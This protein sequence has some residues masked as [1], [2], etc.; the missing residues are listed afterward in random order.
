MKILVVSSYLPY[1]LFSGGSV[2]LFNLLKE[3]SKENEVTLVCEI[4]K[5]Q[6]E[7][8]IAELKKICKKVITVKRKKQWSSGNVFKSVFSSQ[9]FLV[10]GHTLSSMKKAIEKE[11]S[12]NNFDLIHVET[13]YVLQNVPKTT[14][15]IVLIEHNIEYL[16]Y[17]RFVNKCPSSIRRFLRRDVKKI[18]RQEEEAWNRS[19]LIATVSDEDKAVIERDDVFVVRNGVDLNRFN[20]SSSKL[21]REIADT[22]LFIGDFKWLQNQVAVKRIVNEIWPKVKEKNKTLKL[23]VVGKNMPNELKENSDPT[24]F[25]D[26]KAPDDTEKIYEKADILLAPID[27]GGGTSFKILEAMASG[28]AVV[29]TPLG[30]EGIVNKTQNEVVIAD[31]SENL[32]NEVLKLSKD[33]GFRKDLIR[34]ARKLIEDNYDWKKIAKQLEYVYNK[35]LK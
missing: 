29:T 5:N 22:V 32:A 17:D 31:S 30:A 2:R 26:D 21:N 3:I 20:I 16:V 27:V 7:Q 25:F 4:R 11:I 15:P 35:A 1:P 23:W 8:D 18:K 33:F 24:I 6:T 10:T 34:N 14:I 13:F 12:E 19:T 28:V 9:S